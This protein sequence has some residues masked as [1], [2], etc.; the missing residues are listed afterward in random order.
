MPTILFMIRNGESAR[1]VLYLAAYNVAFTLPLL[2]VFLIAWRGAGTQRLLA[3]GRKNAVAGKLLLALFF[4][5]MA[6]LF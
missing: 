1:G 4:F 2:A 5:A 6:A 3:L